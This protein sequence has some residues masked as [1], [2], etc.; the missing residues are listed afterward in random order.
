M[1]TET[2]EIKYS[3]SVYKTLNWA[4]SP[5]LKRIYLILFLGFT[6]RILILSQTN[7]IGVWVDKT[8][9]LN[10]FCP[11]KNNIFLNWSD[12]NII[13]VLIAL[14]IIGFILTVCFRV[15]FSSYSA[16]AV[17]SIYDLVT[18]KTSRFPMRFFD[19]N[20]TGRIITRFSSDYG[21][22]FRLFGGPLAEFIS[23]LFD[24]IAIIILILIASP[25]YF[26][27]ILPI[28]FINYI[29]Y[30]KNTVYLRKER[31]K[32]SQIRSPSIAH[33]AETTQGA[34]IIRIQNKAEIFNTR[35][36]NLNEA[37]NLQRLRTNKKIYFFSYQMNT[38]SSI[39]LLLIGLGSYF[40]LQKN[41]ITL[42]SIGVAF[43]LVVYSGNTI[44]M[45]FEWLS[46]LEEGLIGVE[47]LDHYL[48]LPLEKGQLGYNEIDPKNL[49]YLKKKI[50]SENFLKHLNSYT[51][52]EKEGALT[53]KNLWFRYADNLPW[54]LKDISFTINPGEKVGIIGH[55]GSGKTSLIQALF[56]FY[57]IDQGH[58]FLNQKQ[59]IKDI[60]LTHYRKN[61]SYIS[62]DP[63]L[64]QGSLRENLDPLYMH[65]NQELFECLE[66][67][68][69]ID[70]SE[71]RNNTLLGL[72]IE[73]K[74]KNLSLGERQLLCLAR[75]LIQKSPIVILDEATSSV[76]PQSE[77]IMV[78]AT[79]DFFKD[80]T[81]IIIAHRL[82]T[83]EHCDRVIWLEQG[84]LKKIGPAKEIIEQFQNVSY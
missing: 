62:Q 10:G 36:E 9:I 4:Y 52:V 29:V 81:Q 59:P 30:K 12:I 53:V 19:E 7:L 24:L 48:N 37:Y 25:Y 32:L 22:V 50:L 16:H 80:K 6:G 60:E 49:F 35:F 55:T 8:C 71:S 79:R 65:Q 26:F 2:N 84:F 68:G 75:T 73:E 66:K 77:E 5:F 47:R 44:Q 17:S 3:E 39:T 40:L 42:G 41:L 14:S 83:L 67:V 34:S 64:F 57:P 78:K 74:G 82:S 21:T 72:P 1:T 33:F 58:I 76:D 56:S 23:I 70:K 46:Q 28:G 18:L 69:F 38:I 20:P 11:H 61:F 54:V 13:L 63:V 51:G 27:V 45:F 15:L 43:G 31:R